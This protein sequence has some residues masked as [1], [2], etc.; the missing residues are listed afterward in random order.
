[1]MKGDKQSR[2]ARCSR[3]WKE[4]NNPSR[5]ALGGS[6][7]LVTHTV[8]ADVMSHAVLKSSGI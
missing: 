7:N 4:T 6:L 3:K 1:M 8:I 2:T 5:S